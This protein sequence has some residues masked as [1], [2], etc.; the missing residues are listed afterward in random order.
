[1]VVLFLTQSKLNEERTMKII[2]TVFVFSMCLFL[3][4]CTKGSEVSGRSL[5]SA[6][7]SVSRIKDRLPT[8]QRIEFEVSYWTLRDSIKDKKEFLNT[9]GGKTHEELIELG[10]EV[11]QQ[12]KNDGF[13][14]YDKYNSWDQMITEFTQERLD[15]D[16]HKKIDNRRNDSVIYKL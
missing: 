15:Q 11:F 3:I 5:K 6:N 13:R 2:S 7:K 16:K 4:G 8:D 14:E 10:K 9:V 1:M 12:R